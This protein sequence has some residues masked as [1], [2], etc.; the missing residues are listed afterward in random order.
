MD[1]KEDAF[2]FPSPVRALIRKI[3][4]QRR[5]QLGSLAKKEDQNNKK[6]VLS[7]LGKIEHPSS[8]RPEQIPPEEWKMLG[9]LFTSVD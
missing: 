2:L 7:W 5:K 8:S 3:F 6:I 1:L 9:E 4:T